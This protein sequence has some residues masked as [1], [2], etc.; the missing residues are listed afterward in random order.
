MRAFF[1]MVLSLGMTLVAGCAT[2]RH[3]TTVCPE[4]RSLR[5]AS[6][7]A[8]HVDRE[9]GCRVCECAPVFYVAPGAP[10]PTPQ[11]APPR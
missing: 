7:V 2:V 9:R 5:C 6:D 4:S 10:E 8:C 1:A 3:D 11:V